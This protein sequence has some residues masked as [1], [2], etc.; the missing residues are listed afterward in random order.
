MPNSRA[1]AAMVLH[2]GKVA[3]TYQITTNPITTDQIMANQITAERTR[4]HRAASMP[5]PL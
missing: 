5:L 2:A 1:E 3:M 4:H